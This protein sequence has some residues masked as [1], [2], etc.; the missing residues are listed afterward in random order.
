VNGR[1]INEFD[2]ISIDGTSGEV[3]LGHIPARTRKFSEMDELATLL[4][5]A[6]DIK[7]LG[8]WA[9]ADNPQD[10]AQA[11]EF[12]AEG[13]GLVRTEHM[14]LSGEGLNAVQKLI[15]SASEVTALEAQIARA[16]ENIEKASPTKE[17]ELAELQEK[18]HTSPVVK[19]HNDALDKLLDL[20]VDSFRA[21][22]PLMRG[23]PIVV[24]LLDP[25]LHEFLPAYEEVLVDLMQLFIKGSDLTTVAE[26][27][28]V[29]R[30]VDRMRERNPMLGLR[31]CRLG[32]IYTDIYEMQVK[33]IVGAA[34]DAVKQ[35]V[36]V[37]LSIMLPLISAAQEMV[38]LR[39]SLEKVAEEIQTEKGV[40]VPCEWGAM[41]ETPR[42]ALTSDEIAPFVDFFSFGTND[43]TQATYCF[44]R[45]DAEAKFLVQYI[46]EK[47][48][49]E[50]PFQVLDRSGVGKLIRMTTELGR[51]AHPNLKLGICGEHGGDPQSI[52]FFHQ[53]GLDYVSCSPFRIPI[54]RLAAAQ[55]ALSGG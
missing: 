7:R 30:A 26:K 14:L 32:L 52:A 51:K 36:P 25:P 8:V 47:I 20:Q 3:F 45:D 50:N 46:D 9:N 4:K 54:A 10:V 55:A 33:A 13:V 40:K 49:P 41:V 23:R 5:W 29:L 35:G 2:E 43:L 39:E 31:G 11:I 24:R 12:G 22:F 21:M 38:L 37:N 16:Q 42:A 17:R 28:R 34:C 53:V 19:D 6:D 15:L 44:S 48:L 18:Y 1:A 27:Q